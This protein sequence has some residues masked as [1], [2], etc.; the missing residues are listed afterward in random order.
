MEIELEKIYTFRLRLVSRKSCQSI[1][2]RQQKS[3]IIV[4]YIKLGLFHLKSSG[5]G[6]GL[7]KIPDAPQHIL[8]FSRTPPHTFYFFHGRP[9]HILWPDAPPPT[10]FIFFV[11][12]PPPHIYFLFPVRASPPLSEDLKWNSP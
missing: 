12:A 8:F 1:L 10:H 5:G 3:L 11:N 7:E 2:Q 9:P 4:A 6:D